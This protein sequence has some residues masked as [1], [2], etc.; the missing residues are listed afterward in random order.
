MD[1][2]TRSLIGDKLGIKDR[3]VRQYLEQLHLKLRVNNR[4]SLVLRI[5]QVRDLSSG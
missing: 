1:G 5:I 3:T 2:H 4:V